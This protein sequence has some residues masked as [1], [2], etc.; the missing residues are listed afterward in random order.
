PRTWRQSVR[1]A[2]GQAPARLTNERA[3]YP[4]PPPPWPI[5]F[6]GLG[7]GLG[8]GDG[9]GLGM[10]PTPTTRV[11]DEPS[12]TLVPATGLMLSTTPDF[13]DCLTGWSTTVTNTWIAPS[14]PFAELSGDPT[15]SG[16]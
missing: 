10:G 8:E 2:I 12:L 14:A 16:S 5:P 13:A 11:T 15:T 4:P 1:A 6:P 7:L 3:V 9:L